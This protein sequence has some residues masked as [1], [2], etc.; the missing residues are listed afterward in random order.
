LNDSLGQLASANEGLRRAVPGSSNE[1]QLLDQ[2]DLALTNISKRLDVNVTFADHG[3]AN[4]TYGTTA[5]LNG[6]TPA[7][8]AVTANTDGTLAFSIDGTAVATPQN[9]SLYGHAQSAV[10]A[11]DRLASLNTLAT[12]YV[13]DVNAW[14]QGGFTAAGTPGGPMLSIGANASTLQLLISDPAQV[15]GASGDG[16]VNGNLLAITNIRGSSGVENGWSAIIAA[17]ANLTSATKVEQTAT[18]ARNQQAQTAR[19]DVSGVDLDREAA[20]LLRLQQC[21]E[22]CARIIQVAREITQAL[23]AA[24]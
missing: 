11:R 4:V 3:V 22:G 18:S 12:Q 1:A 19:G 23:F 8:V 9:G 21:Y 24:V 6:I 10:V 7:T 16:R 17:Q 15:A 2:R 20:E 5:L 14:H 13:T